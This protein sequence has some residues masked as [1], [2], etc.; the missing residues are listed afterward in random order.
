MYGAIKMNSQ[1]K[2]S[3]QREQSEQIVDANM[4]LTELQEGFQYYKCLP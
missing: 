3:K 4:L 1:K 2:I